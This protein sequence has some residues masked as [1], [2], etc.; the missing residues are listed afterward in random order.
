MH[1]RQRASVV[2]NDLAIELLGDA[3]CGYFGRG[4]IVFSVRTFSLRNPGSIACTLISA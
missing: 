1:A 3:T 4:R 2:G